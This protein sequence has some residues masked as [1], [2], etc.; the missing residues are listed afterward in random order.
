MIRRLN[1]LRI[2]KNERND[3]GKSIYTEKPILILIFSDGKKN[4]CYNFFYWKFY[5][6]KN[7]ME[8]NNNLF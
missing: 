2:K 1:S 4:D 6:W 5:Y 3:Y 8:N 7:L